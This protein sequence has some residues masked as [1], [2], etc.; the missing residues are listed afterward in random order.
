[1]ASFILTYNYDNQS[2]LFKLLNNRIEQIIEIAQ[3]RNEKGHGQTASEQELR[4][5][6]ETEVIIY[7]N[8]F[9]DLINEYLN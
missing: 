3:L 8:F 9:K 6:N 2:I 1:V 5:L 7:Y 4:P